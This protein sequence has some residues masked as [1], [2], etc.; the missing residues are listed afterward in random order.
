[1]NCPL[2]R[3]LSAGDGV[4]RGIVGPGPGPGKFKFTV[5]AAEDALAGIKRLTTAITL[6]AITDILR[7]TIGTWTVRSDDFEKNLSNLRPFT[8]KY[9]IL[10]KFTIFH[11]N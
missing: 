1:V 4:L 7:T 8:I 9:G 2:S 3:R 11:V 10:R 5:V 6:L